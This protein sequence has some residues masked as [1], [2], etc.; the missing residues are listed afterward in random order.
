MIE[1]PIARRGSSI[2]IE[3]PLT[4]ENRQE[5]PFQ[6]SDLPIHDNDDSDAY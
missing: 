5:V 3:V 1:N 2:A 6:D 4:S